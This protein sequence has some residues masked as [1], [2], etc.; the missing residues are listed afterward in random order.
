MAEHGAMWRG[1]SPIQQA[2]PLGLWRFAQKLWPHHSLQASAFSQPILPLMRG[3]ETEAFAMYASHFHFNGE[4]IT[5]PAAQIF[6]STSGSK[7]FQHYLHNLHW[8]KHFAASNRTLHA[9]YAL[10][11]LGRWAK[12]NWQISCIGNL[13]QIIITLAS[14]GQV[15]AR[16][17]EAQLQTEFL[18]VASSVIHKLVKRSTHTPEAAVHKA[19]ALL[20]AVT[21][22][23]GVEELRKSACDLLNSSID[24]VIHPDGGHCSN[25]VEN[26]ITLLSQLLPL[27]S[28]MQQQRQALPQ[29]ATHAI[30]R[31]LPMLRMLSFGNH[32]LTT[33]RS[34]YQNPNLVKSL[35]VQRDAKPLLNAPHSGLVRFETA[36]ITCV[37]DTRDH[38]GLELAIGQSPIFK[39]AII[40]TR[41]QPTPIKVRWQTEG[42]VLHM[43]DGRGF[44][45]ICFLSADGTDLRV[46]DYHATPFQ[47]VFELNPDV[48]I[49]AMREGA[50][51]LFVTQ[52]RQVWQLSL[53]GGK[54]SIEPG[55]FIS[56]V[57]EAGARIN[58][59]L[60]KQQPTAKSQARK[61]KLRSNLLV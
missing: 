13:S 59:A 2:K 31:M 52:D 29:S 16:R 22:F 9:H 57:G 55:G 4:T 1:E 39:N 43:V 48:K 50:A 61:T 30:D 32:Q 58:W 14:D 18:E 10:R 47:I 51:V 26:L 54:A 44:G 12:S 3:D 38:F 33:L 25:Q 23:K 53:R 15:L 28:A 37:A 27:Q 11:L 8:L 40:T 19:M 17:C 46:E 56:I 42:H 45:R 36:V 60:K 35:L 5:A 21:A 6:N 49:S 41:S 24:K 34:S 7:C 20:Y